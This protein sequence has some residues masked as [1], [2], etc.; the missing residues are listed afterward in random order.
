M[1]RIA[2]AIGV[3]V[4]GALALHPALAQTVPFPTIAR[5]YLTWMARAMDECNPAT[6]TVLGNPNVPSSGCLQANSTTDDIMKMNFARLAINARTGRLVVFGRGFEF[7]SRVIVELKLRVTKQ[8]QDTPSSPPG[9]VPIT[10]ED[11]TV[12]CPGASP[13]FPVNNNGVLLGRAYLSDCIP[14]PGLDRGNIEV[15]DS[16]LLNPDNG[17]KVFARPGIRRY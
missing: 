5:S 7:G 1:K 3:V 12:M 17:N 13:W 14:Y 16:A 6:T 10:F 9:G 8:G 15:L 4:G 11:F 2:A